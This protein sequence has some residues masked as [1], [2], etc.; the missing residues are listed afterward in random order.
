M[1]FLIGIL[2]KRRRLILERLIR[3]FNHESSSKEIGKLL[4]NSRV[5]SEKPLVRDPFVLKNDHP[6]NKAAFRTENGRYN[7][8]R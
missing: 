5:L 6:T 7:M 2:V 3:Y 1:L 4:S 8:I